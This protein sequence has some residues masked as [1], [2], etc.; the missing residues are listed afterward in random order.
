MVS[1]DIIIAAAAAVLIFVTSCFFHACVDKERMSLKVILSLI[2]AGIGFGTV[3]FAPNQDQ[4]TLAIVGVSLLGA[5]MCYFVYKS[6]TQAADATG[7]I[8]SVLAIA[9]SG[10]TAVWAVRS[11]PEAT[12]VAKV[13]P[14]IVATVGLT[15]VLVDFFAFHYKGKHLVDPD[16]MSSSAKIKYL[17][18]AALSVLAA[19]FV[20]AAMAAQTTQGP[21]YGGDS[22]VTAGSTSKKAS[23]DKL[24]DYVDIIYYNSKLQKDAD[25][26]NDYNFGPSGPIDSVKETTKEFWTRMKHDPNFAAAQLWNED[27]VCGTNFL[28]KYYVACGGDVGKA[29]NAAAEAFEKDSALWKK[30]VES[31]AK[32]VK[33]HTV[34]YEI[35]TDYVWQSQAYMDPYHKTATGRPLVIAL[36]TASGFS[37]IYVQKRL[38]DDG[39]IKEVVTRINCGYQCLDVETS[40]WKPSGDDPNPPTPDPNPDPDGPDEVIDPKGPSYD[41]NP[42]DAPKENTEIND[43][44]GPGKKTKE[45]DDP[46]SSDRMTDP[47]YVNNINNLEDINKTQKKPGD[48]N[49]PSTPQPTE[50]TKS[51]NNGDTGTGYGNADAPTTGVPTAR[52][53]NGNNIN[54]QSGVPWGGPT[55]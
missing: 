9:A 6:V 10:G 37:Y 15:V 28:G 40:G 22:S 38:T 48:P 21:V 7:I 8:T 24:E 19:A 27:R 32:W 44:K 51:D 39:Q 25:K 46:N 55:G 52:E 49:T 16:S 1:L 50:D 29:I 54:S 34:G 33:E 47:E 35:R 13:I 11:M 18:A 23:S 17:V 30:T 20:I 45:N 41:K 5:I 2:F 12:V 31:Y 36:R 43:D 42:E 53:E 3:Y 4:S 14:V 26:T